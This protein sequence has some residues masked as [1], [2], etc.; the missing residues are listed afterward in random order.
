MIDRMKV[1][2]IL[3]IFYGFIIDFSNIS[4]SMK[5]FKGCFS[6]KSA[7]FLQINFCKFSNLFELKIS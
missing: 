7:I 1:K 6:Y 4:I 2:S 3:N 5:F